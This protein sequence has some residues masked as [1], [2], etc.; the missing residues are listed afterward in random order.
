MI[1]ALLA[2]GPLHWVALALVL[3]VAEL[4]SGTT[5]LLWPAAAAF[6]TAV[7]A[8]LGITPDPLT[9]VAAFAGATILLTVLGDPLLKRFRNTAPAEG[10]NDP[11]VRLIGQT[12][13]VVAD[14]VGTEGRVKLGDTEWRAQAEHAP[15]PAG[16]DTL[17]AGEQVRVERTD[18][19]VLKVRR[20]G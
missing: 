18:G 2:V 1:E 17:R 15:E 10:L 20:L 11:S 16:A 8:G 4:L 12:A 7:L 3:L 9:Q 6:V 5:Y 19:I 13:T 14:F